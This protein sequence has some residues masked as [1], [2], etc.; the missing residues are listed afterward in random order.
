MGFWDKL[1]GSAPAPPPPVRQPPKQTHSAGEVPYG[2]AGKSMPQGEDLNVL[3]PRQVG[4]F[5]RDPLQPVAQGAPIY[6]NYQ[7]GGRSIF[8]ELG[9]GANATESAASFATA[10]DESLSDPPDPS[11]VLIEQPDLCFYRTVSQDGAFAT[12]TR[13]RYYFS[14]H[15]KG[16]EK[17]LDEFMTAFP[18]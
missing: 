8:V 14:A 3:L 4:P 18:Y 12:W 2:L 5:T 16:G 11:A 7:A 10:K 1:F 13:G 6:A 9:I 15:A 17:D